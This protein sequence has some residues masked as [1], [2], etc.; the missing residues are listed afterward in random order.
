MK[1]EGTE[2]AEW[3]QAKGISAFVLKYRVQGV[4]PY[5][6][7][8]RLLFRGH[9][10]PDALNDIEQAIAYV[11][12]HANEYHI[13]PKQVGVMGFSAGGHL[14]MLSA[15]QS[16]MRPNFVAVVYPV[17]SMSHPDSHKRSRRGM[18]G[19]YKKHNKVMRD[20]LSVEK[21][22]SKNCPPVFLVNCKDDHIVKPRN[23][24]LLDYALTAQGIN[25]RFIQYRTGGHG[26]GAS[27][28]K[29]TAE[30]RAWKDEFLKWLKSLEL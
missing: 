20:S 3:L 27:E 29:G 11:R 18:L 1:A 19:E 7:H 26:F 22:V 28:T 12:E 17:V 5:I 9:Q 23:A 30:C 14:A 6:T 21:H 10:Y 2:V 25:H 24:E 13:N 4:V 8:A 15:E 16:H